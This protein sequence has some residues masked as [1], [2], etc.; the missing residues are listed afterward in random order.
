[1]VS[2]ELWCSSLVRLDASRNV[3]RVVE[4]TDEFDFSER[5]SGGVDDRRGRAT[6]AHGTLDELAVR[7]DAQQQPVEQLLARV[8][9]TSRDS[10]TVGRCAK[11]PAPVTRERLR[12]RPGTLPCR[13]R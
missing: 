4:S 7:L 3:H 9:A 13:R 8:T 10:F 12:V 2:A 1:M 6:V 11:A 5:R